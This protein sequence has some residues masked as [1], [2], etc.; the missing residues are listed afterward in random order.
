MVLDP[1]G[2]TLS[3]VSLKN[4][5]TNPSPQE[6]KALFL[7]LPYEISGLNS[8]PFDLL[9]MDGLAEECATLLLSAISKKLKVVVNTFFPS[10]I[11]ALHFETAKVK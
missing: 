1:V 10:K 3:V 11:C 9:V 7:I 4:P 5:P 6:N 8:N 2:L